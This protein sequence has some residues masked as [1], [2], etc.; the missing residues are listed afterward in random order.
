MD[1]G[2]NLFV[3]CLLVDVGMEKSGDRGWMFESIIGRDG[4]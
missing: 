3:E 4:V 1:V 2:I